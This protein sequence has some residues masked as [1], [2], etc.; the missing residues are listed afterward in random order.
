MT[1]A[2][3]QALLR[4]AWEEPVLRIGLIVSIALWINIV[5]IFIMATRI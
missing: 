1:K 3:L 4:T 2:E 5:F